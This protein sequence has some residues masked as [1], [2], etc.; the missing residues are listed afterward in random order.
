MSQLNWHCLNESC[1]CF[2]IPPQHQRKRHFLHAV[3]DAADWDIQEVARQAGSLLRN[4]TPKKSA[5][6][7]DEREFRQNFP[8]VHIIKDIASHGLLLSFE[9][10][11][12]FHLL[13]ASLICTRQGQHKTVP[14][15]CLQLLSVIK[16]LL[17]WPCFRNSRHLNGLPVGVVVGVYLCVSLCKNVLINIG[18]N[19]SVISFFSRT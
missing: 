5:F 18:T 15:K 6:N 7:Q 9:S 17:Y 13:P 1:N 14:L 8:I 2:P 10:V 3:D 12:V 16:F 19:V 4:D 11:F